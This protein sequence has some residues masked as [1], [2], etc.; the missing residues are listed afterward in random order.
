MP[1]TKWT[2][3]RLSDLRSFVEAKGSPARAAA[4]FKCTVVAVRTKAS[5]LGLRSPNLKE[6]RL[7]AVGYEHFSV[8]LM[9]RRR[10]TSGTINSGLPSS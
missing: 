3:E 9:N 10:R 6:Q 1:K 2:E 7:R 5:E 8:D 4:H